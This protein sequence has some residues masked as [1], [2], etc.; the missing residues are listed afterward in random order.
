[1]DTLMTPRQRHRLAFVL[2]TLSLTTT[3]LSGLDLSVH[4]QWFRHSHAGALTV[5]QALAAASGFFLG[6]GVIL[7]LGLLF[8]SVFLERHLSQ[9]EDDPRHDFGV[10]H[11]LH[12]T[13]G[14]AG[15]RWWTLP[16][17]LVLLVGLNTASQHIFFTYFSSSYQIP[18]LVS[19]LYG[20]AIG[21][22]LTLLS[23]RILAWKKPSWALPR[24]LVLT[25]I[26]GYLFHFIDSTIYYIKPD[27]MW[28][29]SLLLL[30]TFT[31]TAAALIS[32]YRLHLRTWPSRALMALSVLPLLGLLG[33][34]SWYNSSP[35]LHSYL[36]TN[37]HFYPALLVSVGPLFDS[38]VDGQASVLGFGDCDD[39][40]PDISPE[41]MEVPGNGI[42]ENCRGGDLPALPSTPHTVHPKRTDPDSPL[43]NIILITVDA[44]RHDMPFHEVKGKPLMPSVQS[45]AAESV[46]YDR[47]YAPSTHTTES[48]IGLMTGRYPTTWWQH[49][50]RFGA[51]QSIATLLR[52]MGYETRAVSTIF[53]MNPDLGLGFNT[54]DMELS[55]VTH[56]GNTITSAETTKRACSR[57][58]CRPIAMSR[59]RAG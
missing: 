15:T 56:M 2:C 28:L 46:V 49:G 25:S 24:A 9:D 59:G 11:L 54:L 19:I 30:A 36:S 12:V 44:L 16:F 4:T 41:Q 53:S 39:T 32:E 27:A 18:R 22:G 20:T 17:W 14:A 13:L 21:L 45:L 47:A 37:T 3:S 42:D 50:L 7:L 43:P 29:F 38:D 40:N 35:A 55:Q 52:E 26:T 8:A 57:P 58:T 51:R 23:Y 1:M 33:H 6:V 48:M 10:S 34:V 5:A 31:F